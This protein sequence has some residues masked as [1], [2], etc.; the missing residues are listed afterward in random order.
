MKKFGMCVFVV[1]TLFLPLA[2]LAEVNV[3]LTVQE[4]AGVARSTEWV[5]TG[6][7]LAEGACEDVATLRIRSNGDVLPAQFKVQSRWPDESIK[8]VLCTFPVSVEA[9]EAA[10]VTLTDGDGP[11]LPSRLTVQTVNDTIQVETG[12]LTAQINTQQFR[13]LDEVAVGDRVV[14]RQGDTDG[15][16]LVGTDGQMINAADLEPEEVVIE[17]SGPRR[18]CIMARGRF[19]EAMVLDGE[20]MIRWTCRLYFHEGSDRVR[21]HFTLGND[22]AQ[23]ANMPRRE[24]FQFQELR[25]DFGLALGDALKAAAVEAQADIEG[26]AVFRIRQKGGYP[27]DGIFTARL[28]DRELVSSDARSK[29]VLALAGDRGELT[30][31]IREFWQNYPKE[32][33][34]SANRLSINLWPEFAGYPENRDVYNLCGGKQ[35]TH[36]ITLSFAPDK[37]EAVEALAKSINQP[38]MALASPKYYADSGALGLFSPAGVETGNEDLDGVIRRYDDRQRG[39][40]AGLTS[41][42]ENRRHGVYYNWMNWGD[43]NWVCGSA[44]LHYDWTLV[45]LANWLRTGQR[46]FFDWGYSMARHQHDIDL[47]RSERDRIAYRFLSAYEKE[48]S[49]SGQT[50][51]HIST[52]PR[53]MLPTCSHHWIQGQALYAALTGDP[54]AWTSVR[55]SGAEGVRNRMFGAH[56][57]D[58]RK[59]A[60]QARSYGWAIECL[61]AVYAFTGDESCLEDAKTI[62]ENSLWYIFTERRDR[63][64]DMGGPVQTGYLTRP[65][66]DYHWYTG[67][68]RALELMKAITDHSAEWEGRFE[69]MMYVDT[70]AYLYYQTGDEA[71]LER[72]RDLLENALLGRR[73]RFSYRTGAWT[74]EEAKLG[75]SGYIHIAIERLKQMGKA[76]VAD[77]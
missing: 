44:S 7:P 15:A 76:P 3:E 14:L 35:K 8:W 17:E 36:E 41:A 25:L 16:V 68:E 48:T 39:V 71:Y 11:A 66:I 60:G 21:V 1:V 49:G 55:L 46:D 62:F 18:A 59:R 32:Y 75:R 65:L 13:I 45:M 67:D 33:A 72:A 2:A 6:V 57:L 77:E 43:L 63:S 38:L 53:R 5:T 51:W 56:N 61:L 74:K 4:P 50:G 9:N 58:E 23:G 73:P 54:E 22:G 12:P 69:E 27:E 37:Q 70:A 64:G 28:N 29:G 24:Y 19:K 20:E 26:D 31:A 40:P 42:A 30:V 34:A 52:N 10:K 47:P